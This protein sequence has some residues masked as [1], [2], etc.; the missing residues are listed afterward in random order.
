MEGG[1]P[2]GATI[3]LAEKIFGNLG[4]AKVDAVLVDWNSLIPG[5]NA[6]RFD[7]VSAGMAIL[8]ERC[9][10]AAF[11]DPEST[12]NTALMVRDGNP[13]GV[14]TMAALADAPD[15]KLA[16]LAGGIEAKHAQ[17]LGVKNLQSVPD[18]QTGMD[19]V[20]N[21]R[22]DAFAMTSISLNYM[23]DQNPSVPVDVT[24]AF[25]NL[26]DGKEDVT[27][28]AAVFRKEDNSLREAYNKEL[29]KITASKES[30]V[31]VVGAFGFTGDNLPAKE[32][33]TKDLCAGNAG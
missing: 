30:Y 11:S 6:K 26:T 4:I 27:A 8:P 5:L 24:P 1:K 33:K 16:V 14:K 3:A 9:A 31:E 22:A 19:L 20:A 10:Q 2:T 12:Y 23:A 7:M 28:G 29:A 17:A 13:K 18:A 32:I 15:V 21:G 25:T